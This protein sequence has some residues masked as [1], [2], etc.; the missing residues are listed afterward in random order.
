MRFGA[1]LDLLDILN[2]FQCLLHRS[3]SRGVCSQAFDEGFTTIYRFLSFHRS[4]WCYSHFCAN[5]NPFSCI[6]PTWIPPVNTSHPMLTLSARSRGVIPALDGSGKRNSQVRRRIGFRG[7][8]H[9]YSW[10]QL[11]AYLYLSDITV[12]TKHL[13][14]LQ[15]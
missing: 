12:P 11:C 15:L 3:A 2:I 1:N 5:N 4:P 14:H 9:L 6:Y 10:H 8:S 13:Q 7:T